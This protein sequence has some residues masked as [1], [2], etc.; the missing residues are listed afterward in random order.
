MSRIQS[1]LRTQEVWVGHRGANAQM[2]ENTMPAFEKAVELGAHM[3]ELDVQMTSDG[4]VIVLHDAFLDRTTNGSGMVANATWAE[5]SRL[6]AGIH[7]YDGAASGI[8]VPRLAEVLDWLPEHIALNIEVKGTPA[9]FTDLGNAVMK[10]VEQAGKKHQV[11]ISSFNHQ[12]L[13]QIRELDNDIA[14]GALY[15]GKLWP[16]FYTARTLALSSLHETIESI[17]SQWV[18]RVHEEGLELVV[19]TLRTAAEIDYCRSMGV[20]VF[21]VDDLTLL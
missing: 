19:W 13:A 21:I 18:H 3:I 6:D 7:F 4:E 14:L 16:P 12:A 8:H 20:R 10:R 11:L 2:P 15:A 1:L 9:N 17:D 5:V